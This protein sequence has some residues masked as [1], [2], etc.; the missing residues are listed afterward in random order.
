[1]STT[2]IRL[3]ED[4]KTRVAEAALRTGTSMHNFMLQAIAEKTELAERNDDFHAEADRRYADLI[5]TGK[6][7]PWA[8]MRSYLEAHLEGRPT[9]RPKARKLAR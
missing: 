2:T 9:A 7:I 4:L 5:A 1:M 3:P 6:T 8:D